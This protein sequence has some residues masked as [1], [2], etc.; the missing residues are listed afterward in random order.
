VSV[1]DTIV[2]HPSHL[3]C[4]F[5]PVIPVTDCVEWDRFA[6]QSA[7][8]AAAQGCVI[9][10]V[11]VS[12]ATALTFVCECLLEEDVFRAQHQ[13]APWLSRELCLIV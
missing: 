7:C 5:D 10:E 6:Q 11:S 2:D 3:L 13:L 12:N 8:E 1:H 4:C 9:S